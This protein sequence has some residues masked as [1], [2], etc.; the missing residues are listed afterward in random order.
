MEEPGVGHQLQLTEMVPSAPRHQPHLEPGRAMVDAPQG[1]GEGDLTRLPGMCIPGILKAGTLTEKLHSPWSPRPQKAE[2]RE[3]GS[4]A[5]LSCW[6][7]ISHGQIQPHRQHGWKPRALPWGAPLSRESFRAVKNHFPKI[8]VALSPL[9]G[10]KAL[11]KRHRHTVCCWGGAG[12]AEPKPGEGGLS[13][14]WDAALLALRMLGRWRASRAQGNP[15]SARR[16]WSPRTH[17]PAPC[18]KP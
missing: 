9:E 14:A 16:G 17:L 8:V 7:Q 1:G 12:K 2:N 10:L 13:P 18:S 3:D 6:R 15:C 11:Q 5:P 4:P